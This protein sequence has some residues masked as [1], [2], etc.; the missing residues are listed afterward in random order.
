MNLSVIICTYNRANMI[1]NVLDDLHRQIVPQDLAWEVLIIDNNST[2]NTKALV[3]THV[4]RSAYPIRYIFE[5]RQGKSHALNTAI[6]KSEGSILAFT[7]DDV[8][9]DPH[10]V[11]AVHSIF[12]QY[13]CMGMAGR[14]R[15]VWN[16]PK[17]MWLAGEG[18][19]RITG[20]LVEFEFG[21][22]PCL[23][24]E[25]GFGANMAFRR[26]VFEKYGGFQTALGPFGYSLHSRI[27]AA[28][29]GED[30]ELFSRV[31]QAGEKIIYSPSALIFH[32]VEKERT[33]KRYFKRWYFSWG[34]SWVRKEGMP[35]DAPGLAGVPR[36]MFRVLLDRFIQWAF[37]FNLR[38]RFS[39]KL[40]LYLALG[41]IIEAY[42]LAHKPSPKAGKQALVPSENRGDR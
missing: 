41:Q 21:D 26:V 39:K 15:A 37:T 36:Y 3:E 31:I 34:R 42:S 38:S 33:Q 27:P 40:K 10:W 17:P 22:K 7:D 28:R 25:P 20:A 32:P 11:S 12:N 23:L 29:G 18:P 16:V 4:K 5:P 8:N 2:D 13:D 1:S 19:D 24:T 35:E 6:E 14:I 30:V 9:V